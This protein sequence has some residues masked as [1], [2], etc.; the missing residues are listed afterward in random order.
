[1][2]L[3]R[4]FAVFAVFAALHGNNPRREILAPKFLLAST[5][6]TFSVFASNFL[7]G[8]IHSKI[9]I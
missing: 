8:F 5:V 9:G 4:F 3:E 7:R 2:P 1:M 6:K